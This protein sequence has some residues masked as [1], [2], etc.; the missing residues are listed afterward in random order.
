ML[1]SWSE[2]Q[3][4]N[5][6]LES[7]KVWTMML[8][9]KTGET[10]LTRVWSYCPV[11]VWGAVILVLRASHYP[12]RIKNILGNQKPHSISCFTCHFQSALGMPYQQLSHQISLQQPFPSWPG[13]VP[14]TMPKS[15]RSMR[16]ELRGMWVEV[17]SRLSVYCFLTKM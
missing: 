1:R 16:V 17:P 7:S 13:V 6:I 5:I 8:A 11:S 14:F 3:V 9:A 10:N 2:C 4:S 12:T 15:L